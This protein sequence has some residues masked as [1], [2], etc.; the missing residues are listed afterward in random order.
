M[1]YFN[2]KQ[3]AYKRNKVLN[4]RDA[5]KPKISKKDRAFLDYLI[6]YKY[7]ARDDDGI[8]YAYTSIPTISSRYWGDTIYKNLARLDIDFPMIREDSE[9]WKIDDLKKLEVVGV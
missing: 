7:M 5:D 9:P 1:K 6:G 4:R 2:N 3:Q 8:L